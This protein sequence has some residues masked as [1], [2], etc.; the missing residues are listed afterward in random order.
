M[1]TEASG[2]FAT[3]NTWIDSRGVSTGLLV[4]VIGGLGG[5]AI[6]TFRQRRRLGWRVL[7]DEAINQG[8]P[9]GMAEMGGAQLNQNMW[10]IQYR[11]GKGQRA[12]PVKK[13]SLVMI[14]IRN[15]AYVQINEADFGDQ[16]KFTLMFPGRRV[17]HFKIRDNPEYHD[18]VDTR[19]APTPGT[20]NSL[21]LPALTLDRK[22]GFKLLVLLVEATPEQSEKDKWELSR[23]ERSERI[24]LRG[25]V[26]GGRIVKYARRPRRVRLIVATAAVVTL[27]VGFVVGVK[28]ANHA[29]T[30]DP[31]CASGTVDFDGSTAFAPILNEVATEYEQDCPRAQIIVKADGSAIGLTQLE[32]N[33]KTSPPVVAMYDGLPSASPGASYRVLPVGVIIFAMV[34]NADLPPR[35]FTA[36]SG[37]MTDAQIA[38]AFEDPAGGTPALSP[39]GRSDISGTREAFYSDVLH[40]SGASVTYARS[41]RGTMGV[42]GYVNE[43]Q[44]AIGYAEAD[45]L[46]FFPEVRAIPINGYAPSRANVL[47]G[48]Y[49]FLAAEHLYTSGR[50]SGLAADVI[51]FL[52]SRAVTT[53]LRD[54]S[55]IGCPDLGGSRL[56]RYCPMS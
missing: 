51:D 34:G 45:A 3:L 14:E 24:L 49:D 16:R 4:A 1:H 26:A 54:T 50:P 56:S 46:P 55:F 21:A 41:E 36:G 18:L 10:E 38:R 27:L 13:G 48:H 30:P 17:V 43:T 8:D 29:L 6:N 20:Q 19:E 22:D 47:N 23:A 28:L 33:G 31:V 40:S 35:L 37:G 39:V 42:L 15:I 5:W 52:T 2:V 32:Q 12:Y 7:Y 53:Q 44:N 9:F 25:K 11:R